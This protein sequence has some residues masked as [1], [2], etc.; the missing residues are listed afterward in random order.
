MLNVRIF[1]SVLFVI[2]LIFILFGKLYR[3]NNENKIIVNDC[4]LFV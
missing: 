2:K 3:K 4:I 1:Y